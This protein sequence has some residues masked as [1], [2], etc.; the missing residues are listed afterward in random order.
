[1]NFQQSK[2]PLGITKVWSLGQD[3]YLSYAKKL[4]MIFLY[5]SPRH[6]ADGLVASDTR[7]F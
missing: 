6:V 7:I 3:F 2:S 4:C 1:M 5:L